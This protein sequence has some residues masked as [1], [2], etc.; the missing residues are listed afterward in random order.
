MAS[1]TVPPTPVKIQFPTREEWRELV[2]DPSVAKTLIICATILGSIALAG[3]VYL[4]SRGSD[5]AVIG[6]M[7]VA[8]VTTVGAV[9]N[10]R[11][12]KTLDAVREQQQTK[13]EA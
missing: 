12:K 9:I 8:V 13:D 2:N 10:A 4:A 1:F 5:A 11:V 6:T 3:V 7:I